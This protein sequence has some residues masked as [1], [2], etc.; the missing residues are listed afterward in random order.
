M[1]KR[2]TQPK[3]VVVLLAGVGLFG[4]VG[5]ARADITMA[6]REACTPDALR[7]CSSAIPDVAKVKACMLENK[8]NLSA[9]C[10]AAFPSDRVQQAAAPR[11]ARERVAKTHRP[12]ALVERASTLDDP[13]DRAVPRGHRAPRTEVVA[14][15]PSR[16]HH[17]RYDAAGAFGADD[18]MG[19]MRSGR[20]ISPDEAMGMARQILTTY[21]AACGSRAIPADYCAF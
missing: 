18:F 20:R 14:A 8:A 19:M 12:G 2:S 17:R 1:D 5:A 16:S 7:L 4:S 9:G 6:Q 13:R 10:R 3:F 21:R 15:H 11:I